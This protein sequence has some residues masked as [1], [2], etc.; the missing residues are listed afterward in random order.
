MLPPLLALCGLSQP[1]VWRT[2]SAVIALVMIVY[3]EIYRSEGAR[4]WQSQ[5]RRELPFGSLPGRVITIARRPTLPIPMV[6]HLLLGRLHER[7]D[8][9]HAAWSHRTA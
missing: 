2:S 5:P 8:R 9:R 7:D 3:G 4:S 6:L 1:L